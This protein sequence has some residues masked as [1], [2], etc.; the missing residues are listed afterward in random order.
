MTGKERVA[1]T[2]RRQPADRMPVYGW[3]NN[4]EFQKKVEAAISNA[5]KNPENLSPRYTRPD[6]KYEVLFP[7]KPG[8]GN[9]LHK[10]NRK[11]ATETERQEEKEKYEA[12]VSNAEKAL[13]GRQQVLNTELKRNPLILCIFRE[14]NIVVPRKAK[15]WVI[16]SLYGV[17]FDEA[18]HIWSFRHNGSLEP[19][20]RGTFDQLII[21][22][23]R[24]HGGIHLPGMPDAKS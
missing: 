1:R 15:D 6:E 20:F 4:G 16:S 2:I 8:R 17:Q 14:N 10:D 24:K 5:L 22:L 3:V 12:A 23:D 9:K 19:S 21:A 13:Y 7:P 11:K 18:H